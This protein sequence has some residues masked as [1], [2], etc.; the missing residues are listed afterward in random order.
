MIATMIT[1]RT[2]AA[3]KKVVA[4]AVQPRNVRFGPG[5]CLGGA[6]ERSRGSLPIGSIPMGSL[7][8]GVRRPGVGSVIAGSSRFL[9]TGRHVEQDGYG[10]NHQDGDDDGDHAGSDAWVVNGFVNLECLVD[11]FPAH[12]VFK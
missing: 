4:V 9:S 11:A 10:R 2:T 8:I 6:S 1:P 5:P 7:L 12:G 3:M